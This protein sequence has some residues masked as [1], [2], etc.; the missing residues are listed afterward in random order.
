M[1]ITDDERGVIKDFTR[2]SDI[3][4]ELGVVKSLITP[5]SES[6]ISILT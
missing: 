1:E 3:N 6:V 4:N 5:R 2:N